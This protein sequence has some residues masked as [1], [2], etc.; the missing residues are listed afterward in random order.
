MKTSYKQIA[1]VV[2]YQEKHQDV[3]ACILDSKVPH[4]EFDYNLAITSIFHL[5][6][7]KYISTS[8]GTRHCPDHYIK[9]I[10]CE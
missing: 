5:F 9:V 8:W 3:L 1:I 10:E 2:P 7:Q 6:C 4:T